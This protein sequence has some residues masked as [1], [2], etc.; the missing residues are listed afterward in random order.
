MTYIESGAEE[1]DDAMDPAL[2]E[3]L[4]AV[5]AQLTGVSREEVVSSLEDEAGAEA[6]GVY[7]RLQ[8]VTLPLGTDEEEPDAS[9]DSFVG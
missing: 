1:V 5:G 7:A 4:E 3:L 9:M 2:A 8:E 6:R